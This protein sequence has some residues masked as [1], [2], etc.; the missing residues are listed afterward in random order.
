MCSIHVLEAD[1]I[2]PVFEHRA[3]SGFVDWEFSP[4]YE[5]FVP[6]RSMSKGREFDCGSVVLWSDADDADPLPGYFRVDQATAGD[7]SLSQ[8]S[9]LL[10]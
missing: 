5:E 9:I 7:G 2:G 10:A 4:H 6:E 3:T 1:E 8:A